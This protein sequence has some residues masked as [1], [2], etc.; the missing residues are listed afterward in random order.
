MNEFTYQGYMSKEAQEFFNEYL[1]HEQRE[2]IPVT[3]FWVKTTDGKT[4]MLEKN[5]TFI[6]DQNGLYLL[7]YYEKC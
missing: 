4:I 5:L 1:I 7:F 6:K 2:D 3:G